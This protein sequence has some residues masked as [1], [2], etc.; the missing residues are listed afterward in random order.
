M[1][2]KEILWLIGTIILIVI[3]NFSISG[4]EGFKAESVTDINIYDTYFVIS[5]ILFLFL[6]AVFLFFGIYF[7][8]AIKQNFKNLT[9]N[10]VFIIAA[11]LLIAISTG[12]HS[13]IESLAYE[14]SGPS[15]YPPLSSG[16][17]INQPGQEMETKESG[18]ELF[19]SL[20]LIFQI[21]LL[22]LVVYC[23][24]KTGTNYHFKRIV[25]N[26]MITSFNKAFTIYKS[27]SLVFIIGYLLFMIINDY[28]LLLENWKNE[29]LYQ[30]YF[31]YFLIIFIAFSIC[32]WLFSVISIFVYKR[33]LNNRRGQ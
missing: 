19:S 21:L 18:V 8:R 3:T 15:V 2:R 23:G 10:F 16:E 12:I 32:F 7:I 28:N 31:G 5:N 11:I 26:R 22:I 4:I 25:F 20:I 6:I 33:F 14:A 9:A 17:D 30:I 29:I 1:N 27:L 24:Y 13:M